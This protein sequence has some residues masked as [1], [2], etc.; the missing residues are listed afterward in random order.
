MLNSARPSVMSPKDKEFKYILVALI[1]I[2]GM[3]IFKELRPYISGFLGAATLYVI[4]NGQ[5]NFFAKKL[6][7]GRALGAFIILIEALLF[8]LIPLTGIAFLAVDT[9]SGIHIDPEAILTKINEIIDTIEKRTGYELLSPENLSILPKIGSTVVQALGSSLYSFV[10]NMLVILFVL[11]YMLYSSANLENMIREILPF[12]EENKKILLEE[13]KSII[14]ANAIGIPLLAGIQGIFAYFG[15]MFFGVENAV[16]FA[17]MT[18]F[19]TI[20]PILGTAIVWAPLSVGIMISGDLYNGFLLLMYGFFIIG[21][22]D[23]VARFMLQKILAD[24]HP[25]ITVFGVLIGLPMFGFWGVIFGPLLLS[26]FILFLNMYRHEYVP[27]STADPRVTTKM[28]AAK[29]PKYNKKFLFGF[30]KKKK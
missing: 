29:I 28:K 15:Y 16:L 5:M 12:R 10:I 9:I 7:L 2:L 23:N 19:S 25:L 18:A 30:K 14:Q 6:H 22:V 13:T 27:G 24:I 8:F 20:I 4:L 1:V 21:G 26:L 3:V 11:Y 17:F